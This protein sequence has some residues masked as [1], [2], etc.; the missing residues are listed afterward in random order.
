MARS[1][2]GATRAR[3][4]DEAIRLFA[5]QGYG[6]TSVADIQVACGLTAASGALYKHFPS[7]RALLEE[8]VRRNLETVALERAGAT[9]DLPDDP[10]A[11]LILL[12]E[13]VW[14][15]MASQRAL[16]RIMLREF[17]DF[18]DL[19]GQMW[20]GVLAHVYGPVV[21]WLGA[22]AAAG[23]V[24]V[25]DPE[26]AAAVILAS[27]TYYP[28]LDMLISRSPGDVGQQRFLAAWLEHTLAALGLADGAAAPATQPDRAQAARPE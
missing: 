11:A 21:G 6:A 14:S 19:F 4:L 23:S 3:L 13:V 20:E 15:V 10:R 28:I 12:A 24:T 1:T 7:K 25:T 26:A 18:P 5:L 22:L 8:A 16:I 9:A 27:L 17:D 2:P